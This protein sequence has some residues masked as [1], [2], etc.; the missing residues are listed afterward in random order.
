MHT[1][2]TKVRQSLFN[3]LGNAGKFTQN[4]VVRL[5]AERVQSAA[6]RRSFSACA[7]R[8]WA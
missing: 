8:A 7:T 2:V 3:L 4:G 1:D 6:G 5:E